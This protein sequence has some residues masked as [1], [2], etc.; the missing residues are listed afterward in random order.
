MIHI[1]NDKGSAELKPLFDQLGQ[2]NKLAEIRYGDFTFIGN[3][4]NGKLA[5]I[6]VE[7]KTWP[8]FISS[9][10]SNRFNGDQL[11]GLIE[12]YDDVYLYIEGEARCNP[13]T[14]MFEYK[15][16][17]MWTTG[18]ARAKPWTAIKNM[19]TTFEHCSA[20]EKWGIKIDYP[21]NMLETARNVS[22]LYQ[23]YNSKAWDEHN[24]H[25][26]VK[27]LTFNVARAGKIIR[28]ARA[29]GLGHIAAEKAEKAFGS[30]KEMVNCKPDDWIWKG[31]VGTKAQ[32]TRLWNMCN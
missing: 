9:T 18:Y 10:D 12:H 17:G 20:K 13:D 19:I 28:V 30:V 22:T 23:W 7:R 27:E 29:L 11:A 25:K 21:L 8:D 26:R 32:A 5:R 3:G 1:A 15:H 14:N 31:V 16:H 24:S 2:P 6:A 4:P